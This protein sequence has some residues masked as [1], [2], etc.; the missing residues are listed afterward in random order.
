MT[1]AYNRAYLNNFLEKQEISEYSSAFMIDVDYFKEY[2]DTHG[3]YNGDIALKNITM[4]IKKY[5]KEDMSVIRYGGEEFLIL[6]ICKDYRKAKYL[7]KKLCKV[8]KNS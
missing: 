6:S 2:N 7:E 5:L 4:I 3:H 8:V 1:N